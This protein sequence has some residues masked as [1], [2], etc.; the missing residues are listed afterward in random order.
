MCRRVWAAVMSVFNLQKYIVI[1][2]GGR[3]EKTKEKERGR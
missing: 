2:T 3:K 1:S